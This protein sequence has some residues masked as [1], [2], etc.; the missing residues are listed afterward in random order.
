MLDDVLR[1]VREVA[2]KVRNSSY[3]ND[4]M[5]LVD[6]YLKT[7]SFAWLTT[8]MEDRDL[9]ENIYLEVKGVEKFLNFINSLAQE[10]MLSKSEE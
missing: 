6:Y 10:E 7:L 1:K 5:V 2:F 9:R 8:K 3:W 4:V